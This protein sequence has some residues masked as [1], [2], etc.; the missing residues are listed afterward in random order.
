MMN[1]SSMSAAQSTD[2]ASDCT[3]NTIRANQPSS[4]T[5]T[6]R[7]PPGVIAAI[8][9]TG[10]V[11]PDELP[12]MSKISN[13]HTAAIWAL[14]RFR[15]IQALF[16]NERGFV[17]SI[18]LRANKIVVV[19][20][21]GRNPIILA[22]EIGSEIVRNAPL[23][24]R[25]SFVTEVPKPSSTPITKSIEGIFDPSSI[26]YLDSYRYCLTAAQI[27]ELVQTKTPFTILRDRGFF[28]I[29]ETGKLF[30]EFISLPTSDILSSKNSACMCTVKVQLNS[31]DDALLKLLSELKRAIPEASL[32]V[33]GWVIRLKLKEP[34][35]DT[36]L[37][38]IKLISPMI[39]QVI[40]DIKVRA[41]VPPRTATGEKRTTPPLMDTRPPLLILKAVD[42]D[43]ISPQTSLVIANHLKLTIVKYSPSSCIF[44]STPEVLK[45]IPAFIGGSA[46]L[47]DVLPPKE[48]PGPDNPS[49]TF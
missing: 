40:P 39:T 11:L 18:L 9:R 16:L 30:P 23:S 17:R 28:K 5:K 12:V 29:V 3:S 25:S 1:L 34:L 15:D 43:T 48:H 32:C 27:E 4:P 49:R 44:R 41:S 37:S 42:A 21:A 7:L 19:N 6:L 36:H 14:E 10:I 22:T 24:R 26:S 45:M 2:G 20:I 38:S 8:A 35:T 33:S 31:S 13:H 47:L 46:F